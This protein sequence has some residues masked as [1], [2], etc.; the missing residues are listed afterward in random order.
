M[1]AAHNDEMAKYMLGSEKAAGGVGKPTSK[2]LVAIL[3]E[4]HADRTLSDTAQASDPEKSVAVIRRATDKLID[5][6]SQWTVRPGELE[7]KFAESTNAVGLFP[8]RLAF[9]L[10]KI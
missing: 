1:T 8:L 5:Y 2:S 10:K 3:K 7:E 9:S 4:I 6:A